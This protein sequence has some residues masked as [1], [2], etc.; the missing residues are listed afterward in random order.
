MNHNLPFLCGVA[1]AIHIFGALYG[2][3]TGNLH[4][5]FAH[6]CAAMWVYTSYRLCKD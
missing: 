3:A 2:F 1:I 6:M 5:G 4:A